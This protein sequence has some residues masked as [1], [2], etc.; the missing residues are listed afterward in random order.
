MNFFYELEVNERIVESTNKHR[1][2]ELV[3][4]LRVVCGPGYC[5]TRVVLS[6]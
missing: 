6:K 2:N 1:S 5:N 4:R 3:V